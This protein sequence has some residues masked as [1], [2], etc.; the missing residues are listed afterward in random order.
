MSP[1]EIVVGVDGAAPS[2]TALRW[3][4]T[5]AARRNTGLHVVFAYHW[6]VPGAS[7]AVSAELEQ[8]AEDI[9]GLV[10]QDA[11]AEARAT[12]P[13]IAVRGHAILGDAAAVLLSAAR[14][15]AL[16]VVG[17]RGRHGFSAT[18]LG[19]ISQQVTLHANGPVAIIRDQATNAG[20]VIVGYDGSAGSD[21]ALR[22]AFEEANL[23]NC[24]LT[25]IQAFA[26]AL[27]SWP[28]ALPPVSY[29]HDRV[30]VAMQ[31]DLQHTLSPWPAKY[32]DVEVTAG[33]VTGSPA[34][35]LID[36]S[37]D[38]DLVVIGSRGHGGFAGL[39]LG[40]VGLHLLHRAE[41]PLLIARAQPSTYQA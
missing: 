6:Q 8:A 29:D 36:A 15:S 5:E 33:V 17:T 26:P 31:S 41:C 11:V 39:L 12:A 24:P 32:P 19:S 16:L 22:V 2:R 28:V 3:A 30:R 1:N 38:A 4:A 40:S 27:P 18:L 20:R 35:V 25:V 14:P 7:I 10:V 23:R 13:G 21:E 37:K 34:K 9:A